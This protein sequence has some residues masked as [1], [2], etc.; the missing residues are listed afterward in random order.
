M[1]SGVLEHA[2]EFV[3]GIIKFLF[4]LICGLSSEHISAI[5]GF[6]MSN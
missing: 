4:W 1:A 3:S 5:Y 6:R 2:C